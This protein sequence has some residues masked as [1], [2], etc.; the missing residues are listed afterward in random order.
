M[1]TYV[2][3]LITI[4]STRVKRYYNNIPDIPALGREIQRYK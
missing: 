4:T 2:L 3:S 1:N